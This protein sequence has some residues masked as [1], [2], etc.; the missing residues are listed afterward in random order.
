LI[1][2]SDRKVIV[3]SNRLP[4]AIFKNN[5]N[6][7]EVRPGTGGLVTAL[8]PIIR[9]TNGVWIGWPGYSEDAP[10]GKLLADYNEKNNFHLIPV[11]VTEQEIER[12]YRGFSNKSI[13]PLF[14]DLLGQFSYDLSDLEVYK[15]VN[16]KF[17]EKIAEYATENDIIWVHDY[18]LICVGRYLR[19]LGFTRN[20][21]FFLHI[22]FPSYDLF[23]RFPHNREM[24]E[25]F[26]SYNHIGFQ[27]AIDR[28]NFVSSLKWLL[29]DT[30]HSA[31]RRQTYIQHNGRETKIGYYPISID[32]DDFNNGGKSREAEEAAWY[33]RENIKVGTLAL[34][35][36]RLDYTKGIPERFQGFERLLEKYPDTVAKISLLQIVVPSRLNVSEYQRLKD[37]LDYLVGRINSRFSIQGWVPIY[38]QFTTLD[39][40]QLL[41]HYKASDIALI[42]PLRDGMNLI[43][44]EY[45]AA[46]SD[47]PGVLILSEFTGAA[48]QLA[49]GAIMVNPFD[50]DQTADALYQAL[51]MSDEEKAKRMR[52]MRSEIRR[53]DLNRWVRWFFGEEISYQ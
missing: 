9:K 43:S 18:Q 46:S 50:F 16:K 2:F 26:L 37:E 41:G 14:H 24:I 35:L 5:S 42:T 52:L 3:V 36:D 31:T 6:E 33:L 15:Q 34:G 23:R 22:P 48:A 53:N 11:D 10:A 19:E 28:R 49:K 29:P 1:E 20:M 30:S 13:W 32:F 47:N 7:W 25:A 12:Y 4:I 44:K 45:C 51:N 17:A 39:R 27:T 21:N 8:E 40:I 38:Y